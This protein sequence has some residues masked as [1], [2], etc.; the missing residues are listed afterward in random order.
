MNLTNRIETLACHRSES[1]VPPRSIA[2][3]KCMG[4][5]VHQFDPRDIVLATHKGF[6]GEQYVNAVHRSELGDFYT[7]LE[8][9]ANDLH[10]EPTCI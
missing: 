5:G 10:P 3:I 4:P 6:N 8:T 9:T 1:P 7:L 2:H